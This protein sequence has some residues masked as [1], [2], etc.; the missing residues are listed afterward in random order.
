MRSMKLRQVQGSI[1][2]KY[3]GNRTATMSGVHWMVSDV[4][5]QIV[6]HVLSRMLQ[7]VWQSSVC[8]S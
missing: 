7:F 4:L 8:A 1:S 3:L 6:E 2:L 5:R